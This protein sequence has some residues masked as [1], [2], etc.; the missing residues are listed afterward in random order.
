[1]SLQNHMML[2]S[3]LAHQVL[4]ISTHNISFYGGIR[5]ISPLIL[6]Y[7]QM[8]RTK[9]KILFFC[10]YELI[11]I[12]MGFVLE[13]KTAKKPQP[14]SKRSRLPQAV[15]RHR[16]RRLTIKHFCFVSQCK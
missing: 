1:M 9:T 3:L 11:R 5:K 6:S 8:S 4:L 2:Y 7:G 10:N 15:Y 12:S 14:S 16:K 13:N